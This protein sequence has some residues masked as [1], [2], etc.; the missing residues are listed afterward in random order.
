MT[1]KKMKKWIGYQFSTGVEIGN[2]YKEFQ[3]DARADL[4]K[5]LKDA[6]MQLLTFNGSHYQFSAVAKNPENER[7]V[8][9]SIIDVRYWQD[10]WVNTVLCRAMNHDR[11]WSGGVNQYCPWNQ[12]G[13]KAKEISMSRDRAYL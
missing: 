1:T 11:D 13:E 4:R 7:H 3:K 12:V 2:D 10:K 8:Y 6:G 9:I 5:M